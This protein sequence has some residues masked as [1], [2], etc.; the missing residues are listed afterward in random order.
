VLFLNRFL[1]D[2]KVLEVF[3]SQYDLQDYERAANLLNDLFFSEALKK[4]D[5]PKV[6]ELITL[7]SETFE[8]GL[9]Y[10]SG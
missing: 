1:F 9:S 8:N 2:S 7:I 4:Y 10:G 6:K 5:H 3:Y